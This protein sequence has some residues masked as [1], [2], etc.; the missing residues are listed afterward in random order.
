MKNARL[1]LQ[2]SN[3]TDFTGRAIPSDGQDGAVIAGAGGLAGK[4]GKAIERD[5]KSAKPRSVFMQLNHEK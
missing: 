1:R 2:R 5:T 3:G 4:A